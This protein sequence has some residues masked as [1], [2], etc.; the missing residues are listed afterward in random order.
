LWQALIEPEFT[1]LYWG[2]VT[3]K[4]DWNA[5]SP[6]QSFD[7]EGAA[8]DTGVLLAFEPPKTLSYSWKVAWHS[9]IQ[10]GA[11]AA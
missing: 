11:A 7:S 6:V 3:L 2:G 4:S 8:A 1:K 10:Q 9:G 5:G